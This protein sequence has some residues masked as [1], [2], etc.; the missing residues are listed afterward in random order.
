MLPTV[1]GQTGI[2]LTLALAERGALE[3]YGV[4]L[5]GAGVEALSWARIAAVQAGDGGDRAQGAAER[6]RRDSRE[7][8]EIAASSASR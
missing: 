8:H 1:G 7:A 4:E 3:R 2:N 5:L 6:L